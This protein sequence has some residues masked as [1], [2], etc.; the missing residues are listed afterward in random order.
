MSPAEQHGC[1]YFA[2][3]YME[4]GE[5]VGQGDPASLLEFSLARLGPL[6][7]ASHPG[8][9]FPICTVPF[10]HFGLPGE[11]GKV[12]SSSSHSVGPPT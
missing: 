8:P 9:F 12:G 6:L 5:A 7:L 4:G 1:S 3:M 10:I 2:D 11:G